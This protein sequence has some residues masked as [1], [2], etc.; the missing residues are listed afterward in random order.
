MRPLAP[1]SLSRRIVLSLLLAFALVAAV[2]VLND[3][4][5]FKRSMAREPGLQQV[6]RLMAG[7]LAAEVGMAERRAI[8][9]AAAS[10]YNGLRAAADPPR[11]PLLLLLR[12]ARGTPLFA[13][14]ATATGLPAGTHGKVTDA[15]VGGR[16]YWLYT[17]V[18]PTW[19]MQIAEPAI[20]D[21]TVL[22]WIFVGLLPDMLLAFPF[23]LVPVWLAV[24]QGLRPLRRLSGQIGR[25]GR[26]DFSPLDI[27]VHYAE[28]DPLIHSF[29]ALLDRLRERMASERAFVQDAAHELRTPMAVIAAQAHALAHA[30]DEG[31]RRLGEAALEQAI[32]RASHLT[33]QLLELAS[34]DRDSPP[35]QAPLDL[36]ALLQ[37]LLA[38]AMPLAL[39][40]RIEPT[41]EAPDSL[42]VAVDRAVLQSIVLNLLDNAIRYGREDGRIV[43]TLGRS[44]G[45]IVLEVADDGPG[46][47]PADREAV[48][49]RFR[50]GEGTTARGTGLGLAIVRKATQ[51]LGGAVTLSEGLDGRGAR[52]IVRFP[53]ETR[54][55]PASA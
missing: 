40:R 49:E 32:A 37:D 47:P 18:A 50:R 52:F 38:Q 51:R 48:F 35:T 8:L 12:D 2:L 25:R 16:R 17:H 43:V 31:E 9:A 5:S 19:A 11:D 13:A 24:R 6:G 33:R 42:P 46:I 20:S 1:P 30:A 55:P 7:S 21:G 45:L 39:K 29:N 4:L 34:L 44:K 27:P 14:P 26:D 23:V 28:L 41:L 22:G 53:A 3:Y 15:E 10:Q 54:A 36:A